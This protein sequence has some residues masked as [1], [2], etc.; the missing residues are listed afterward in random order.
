MPGAQQEIAQAWW[1]YSVLGSLAVNGPLMLLLAWKAPPEEAGP[2]ARLW[3]RW[4]RPRLQPG[5]AALISPVVLGGMV[6]GALAAALSSVLNVLLFPGVDLVHAPSEPMALALQLAFVQA[7]ALEEFSK[8]GLAS[9][10]LPLLAWRSGPTRSAAFLF[11]GAGL[12]F[13]IVEDVFYLHNFGM[14]SPAGMLL[15]RSLPVHAMINFAFGMRLIDRDAGGLGWRYA[16]GL[17]LAVLWHGIF[18]FFAFPPVAFAQFLTFAFFL[19][20]AAYVILRFSRI[21]ADRVERSLQEVSAAEYA[22]WRASLPRSLHRLRRD[23]ADRSAGRAVELPPEIGAPGKV[24]SDVAR[25]S[26]SERAAQQALERALETLPGPSPAFALRFQEDAWARRFSAGGAA[27]PEEEYAALGDA[28]RRRVFSGHGRREAPH[29]LAEQWLRYEQRAAM[30]I[31]G[32]SGADR[33]WD[34][35]ELAE[36]PEQLSEVYAEA[37]V[38]GA[39][40]EQ[41]RPFR[42]LEFDLPDRSIYLSV[43]LAALYGREVLV[44]WPHPMPATRLFFL[45]LACTAPEQARWLREFSAFLADHSLQLAEPRRWLRS[46]AIVPCIDAALRPY[47]LN[48]T[49]ARLDLS[50]EERDRPALLAGPPLEAGES[51]PLQAL[52]FSQRDGWRLAQRGFEGFFVELQ[53]RGFSWNNDLRR[54]PLE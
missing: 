45:W 42:L 21:F 46:L 30:R 19:L 36:N 10:L 37:R 53:N 6:C 25:A 31:L 15:A 3:Q 40:L 38:F 33:V 17:L 27:P 16:S 23:G 35:G 28:L 4:I 8:I 5:A 41:L 1:V 11:G 20:T 24:A 26:S 22:D 52:F 49:G 32:K 14:Q 9:I 50:D 44:S 48:M 13:A 29:A 51:L 43:G 2:M 12:G 54:P 18:D 39:D 34:S 7:G 47:A